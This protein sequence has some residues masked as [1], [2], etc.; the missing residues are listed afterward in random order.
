VSLT[1]AL[2]LLAAQ[3]A[4]PKAVAPP[5]PEA[6][7]KP[8]TVCELLR[9]ADKIRDRDKEVTVR[10]YMG[11]DKF[12]GYY[13]M[14]NPEGKQCKE[15]PRKAKNWPPTIHL[16]WPGEN[17]INR[18]VDDAVRQAKDKKV[19]VTYTGTISLSKQIQIFKDMEGGYFGSAY[20][21]NGQH[22]IQI[23][24]H[25]VEDIETK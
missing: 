19:M 10:G 7:D 11:G 3:A 5:T 16:Q 20:G 17:Q 21:S 18:A 8:M 25:K 23:T 15:M 9:T 6:N 12:L 14:D 13:L 22:P 24:I 1:L 2:L 4:A